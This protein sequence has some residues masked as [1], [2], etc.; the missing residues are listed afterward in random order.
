MG[1]KAGGQT[2]SYEGQKVKG[3]RVQS[4]VYGSCIPV[5]YGRNR[6]AGNL[7]W[8]GDFRQ[9]ESEGGGGG[10]A[11]KGGGVPGAGGGKGG[12]GGGGQASYSASVM[13]GLCHGPVV[14]FQR[15]WA[16]DKELKKKKKERW[17]LF[18][19]AV[20]QDPWDYLVAKF[21]CVDPGVQEKMLIVDEEDTPA[22]RRRRENPCSQTAL[23]YSGL[24]YAAQSRMKLG[25][26]ASLPNLNFEIDGFCQIPSEEDAYASDV[27]LDLLTNTQYGC[28]FPAARIDFAAWRVYCV[29]MG[30]KVSPVYSELSAAGELV[31]QL[32]DLSNTTLAWV[33][34]KLV[35]VPRGDENFGVYV[36]P[37]AP[38][39]DLTDD[40]YLDT[41]EPVKLTRARP[42]DA[43]NS[44]TLEFTNRDNDYASETV[45]FRDLARIEQYGLRSEDG[46][47][48]KAI[49]V[50]SIAQQALNCMALRKNVLNTYTF[51]LGWRYSCL[52][53][54]DIVTLTDDALGLNEQWVRIT[55]IEEQGD[56]E[57]LTFTAEEY[58]YGTGHPAE[59]AFQTAEGWIGYEPAVGSASRP[60]IMEPTGSLLT[61]GLE[62]WIAASGGEEW[63]GCSV[64]ASTDGASYKR[65]GSVAGSARQGV[66][67][68]PWPAGPEWDDI[69]PLI[70]DLSMSR[71]E[72]SPGDVSDAE[73]LNTLCWVDGEWAAFSGAELVGANKYRLTGIRRGA[74]NQPIASHAAGSDFVRVDDRIVRYEVDPVLIGETV[75]LKLVSLDAY[76]QEE[77]SLSEVTAYPYVIQGLGFPDLAITKAELALEKLSGKDAPVSIS[78]SYAISGGVITIRWVAG[79]DPLIYGFAIYGGA[80]GATLSSCTKLADVSDSVRS[81][82]EA[83]TAQYHRYYVVPVMSN[84]TQLRRN[85]FVDILV[86][87]APQAINVSVVEPNIK[88]TW[89]AVSGAKGYTVIV[90]SGF[91]WLIETKETQYLFPI[92]PHTTLVRVRA[93]FP[94]GQGSAY[95]EEEID[96]AGIYN[97]NE[98]VSVAFDFSTGDF[99]NLV[100][101]NSNAIERPSIRGG[102]LAAPYVAN[103]NDSDLW[104]LV[105]KYESVDVSAL[106]CLVE[107]FRD[108]WWRNG[109]A[110]YESGVKDFG[111]VLT[112]RLIGTLTKSVVDLT[113]LVENYDFGVEA[114]DYLNVED[115]VDNQAH[116]EGAFDVSVDGTTWTRANLLDWVTARYVRFF[117]SILAAS[118][119]LGITVTAG[120]IGLDVPDITESGSTSVTG[121]TKDITFTKDF[122]VVNSVICNAQG[123][124]RAWATNITYS[125]FRINLD[126]NP[127]T[128]TVNW[129]AKGY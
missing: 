15:I 43:I 125:G 122:R 88:V 30:W 60:V 66:L 114:V 5:I 58:L 107:W 8:Y 50:K 31:Q 119:M 84:G 26:S 102:T 91:A 98:V 126:S 120:S 19:G 67:V 54:M 94:D 20:G 62:L 55:E 93:D 106:D 12:G 56:E 9:S 21:T 110:W 77:E 81:Y 101:V 111:Y 2:Q 68:S 59:H 24:A 124:P 25:S 112:G 85:G 41:E 34:G 118:P 103:A 86:A 27:A 65:V 115:L 23:A 51:R 3:I 22:A 49:T 109:G 74:Y 16:G 90:D 1:G 99:S 129:F 95:L 64:W 13:I 33:N 83:F 4:S 63:M 42:S 14:A 117:V 61:G 128:T 87:T 18:L 76:G 40:D 53:L 47:D 96:T 36:A 104:N 82:S 57:G 121:T 38:M 78:V 123:S 97:W 127:G 37:S 72:L 113:G 108:G 29:A 100:W 45:E 7:I 71:G 10:G 11:G 73:L 116:V 89:P 75:Y 46:I 92:L 17:E 32:A 35:G 80:A 69:N 44:M 48:G 70:V 39:F 105:D 6:V 79:A 28:G 52:D